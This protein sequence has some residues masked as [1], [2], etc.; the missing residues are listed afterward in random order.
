[1]SEDM[2]LADALQGALEAEGLRLQVASSRERALQILREDELITYIVGD[3]PERISL[4]AAAESLSRNRRNIA[5]A[6]LPSA[7]LMPASIADQ[8]DHLRSSGVMAEFIPK[9][10]DL[11]K[12]LNLIRRSQAR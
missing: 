10:L 4:E 3:L 7:V 12:L 1:M 8:E 6:R 5:W 11:P 2:A 9:P